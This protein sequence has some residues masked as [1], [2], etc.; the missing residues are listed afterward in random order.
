MNSFNGTMEFDHIKTLTSNYVK[1]YLPK[2][3]SPVDKIIRVEV[4]NFGSTTVHKYFG[5]PL[6][7]FWIGFGL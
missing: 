7:N 1:L 2:P 5:G 6:N 3:K 4:L